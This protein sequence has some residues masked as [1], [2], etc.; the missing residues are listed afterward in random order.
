MIHTFSL[1]RQVLHTMVRQELNLKK[2]MAKKGLD[3]FKEFQDSFETLKP[4][5][6]ATDIEFHDE[7]LE[8]LI[9]NKR[10]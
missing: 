7:R 4:L 5:S 1:D 2:F 9:K 8:Q 6:K 3:H 10:E